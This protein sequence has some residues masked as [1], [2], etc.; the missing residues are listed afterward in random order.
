[1]SPPGCSIQLHSSKQEPEMSTPYISYRIVA[2][3]PLRYT[4]SSPLLPCLPFPSLNRHHPTESTRSEMRGGQSSVLCCP[5]LP[6]TVLFHFQYVP[7][8]SLLSL[9]C[10]YSNHVYFCFYQALQCNAMRCGTYHFHA[11]EL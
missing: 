7:S 5:A 2:S 10:F 1:M 8:L 6:D 11:L 9:F 3:P 4:I